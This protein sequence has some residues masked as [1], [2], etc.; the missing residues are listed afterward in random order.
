MDDSGIGRLL[1]VLVAPVRTFR[2]LAER[3]TWVAPFVLLV[4]LSVALQAIVQP[5][6]DMRPVI[7]KSMAKFGQQLPP[8]QLDKIV[9]AASHPSPVRRGLQVTFGAISAAVVYLLVALAFWVAFKLLG[10]DLDYRTSLATALYAF[11]PAAVSIL[12]S[13]PVVLNR[14]VLHIEDSTVG[15]LASNPAVFLPA[16][17]A[18]PLKALLASFDAFSLWGL[19]LLIVGYRATARVSPKAAAATVLLLWLVYVTGKVGLTAL[20]SSIFS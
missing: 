17:T 16:D 5:R 3:P 10:S 14:P 15:Y 9:D 19:V 11:M 12:L 13:I 8:E 4:L 18:A 20:F 6:V 7:E 1:G 2:S